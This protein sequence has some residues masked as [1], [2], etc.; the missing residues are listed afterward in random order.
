MG[1][2]S[3][4]LVDKSFIMC[5]PSAGTG[6][7]GT[8]PQRMEWYTGPESRPITVFTD[9]CF[10]EVSRYPAGNTV[11]VAWVIEP[12]AVNSSIYQYISQ[13]ENQLKFDYIFTHHRDLLSMGEKFKFVPLAG[14]WIKPEDRMIHNKS[15]LLS[16]IAS[17]KTFAP[18]HRLRHDIIR[19][20]QSSIEGVYGNGYTF[21]PYKLEG[22]KDFM[23]HIVVENVSYD[24]WFTEKLID[25]FVTGCIPV[26]YGCP[27]IGNFFDKE[28]M[29]CFDTIEQFNEILETKVNKNYYQDIRRKGI[30]EANFKKAQEYLTPEDYMFET[31]FRYIK[32]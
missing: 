10:E 6:Q 25:A 20:H 21:V 24:Y 19:K 17:S 16:I 29:L 26:Y 1:K 15:K 18:G 32:G 8:A 7:V 28:G 13:Y 12:Y 9:C 31:L 23:F 27:S 22:L 5:G 14:N 30:L 11:R 3:V 2:L 4:K